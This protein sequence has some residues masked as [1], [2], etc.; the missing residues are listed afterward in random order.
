MRKTTNYGLSLYETTDKM[1]ITSS[2]NSLN[3]NMEIID[4]TLKEKASINDMTNYIEEHKDE[5]KGEKGDTGERGEQGPQGIQGEKGDT[6]SQGPSGKDGAKGE[7]G[8]KGDTGATGSKGADGYTPIKGTDYFTESD[9]NE[10]ATKSAELVKTPT[11]T[12][13]LENDSGFLTEVELTQE[14]LN[15]IAD[16]VAE[17][18]KIEVVDSVEEMID[19]N[20]S[21]VLSSTGTI[22]VYKESTRIEEVTKRDD[23]VGTADNPYT[24]GRFSSDGT[25]NPDVSTHVVTPY[26]DFSKYNGKTIELHLDGN[27]Y[28][29]E[30][31]ETYIM[32]ALW[33]ENKT[34]VCGRAS[35]TFGGAYLGAWH[36][37]SNI[38]INSEKSA[39]LTL[40]PPMTWSSIN[41]P[42]RYVRF[43]GLGSEAA[44]NVYITYKET[45][46]ITG[47][48]WTDTGVAFGGTGGAVDEETLAKISTLNNEGKDPTT[49]K[50]LSKPVLDFYNSAT[51]PSDDYTVT[52]LGKFTYPC[53]ADIPVPYNVKW[54]H[55]ENA[56]RTFV[57]LDTKQIGTSNPY[58][59]SLWDATGFDSYAI[60]NLLPNKT[61]Y[62]KVTHVLADGSIVE[63]KSGNFTTSNEAL[64]LLYIEGTQ[65]VRDL[66]G[67]TGLNG[68]K[69]KYGKIIR[70]A[71]LSD[72]SYHGLALTG[73][74]KLAFGE[75]K[76][77]AELNLGAIDKETEGSTVLPL[78]I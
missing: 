56:M 31:V 28:V 57:A 24:V 2:E 19:E 36:Q 41:Q 48:M 59:M 6:G 70:G 8:E 22:W 39:T 1:N 74:G 42:F 38:A 23:I 29:S 3:A 63:A 67:W 11:K 7:K 72:S 53:R 34:L 78:R 37:L 27:R 9:I 58:S 60:Y 21:Y 49:I 12:S 40:T 65:N 25:V 52:H 26:I 18:Q 32:H 69:V 76:V 35:S 30:S 77:Q 54:S 55:N 17:A 10:I 45:Q 50:L 16:K 47:K 71:S 64:R 5:L 4:K 33:G 73:K 13:E 15:E 68:K 61:Y 14:Q 66:G 44:S 46:T 20:K 51:Y 62:Y 75:L 43:C